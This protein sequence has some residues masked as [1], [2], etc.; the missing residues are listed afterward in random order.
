MCTFLRP[1]LTLAS[2]G[3]TEKLVTFIGAKMF[4]AYIQQQNC[5]GIKHMAKN[6]GAKIST[7]GGGWV[8]QPFHVRW[9]R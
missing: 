5:W 1:I 9:L 7:G 6:G 2:V 4:G 8:E 3:N